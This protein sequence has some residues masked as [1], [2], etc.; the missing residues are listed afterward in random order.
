[1][2]SVVK[3]RKKK[4]R[5]HK[6][7]KMLKKTRWQRKH[8]V[9]APPKFATPQRGKGPRLCRGPFSAPGAGFPRYTGDMTVALKLTHDEPRLVYLALV[10][11]LGRPGSEL[12]RDKAAGG[13]RLARGQGGARGTA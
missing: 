4:M 10:Y 11:H 13:A 9:A 5:K 3:K 12:D 7:R 1:M 6:H 2:S 8:K